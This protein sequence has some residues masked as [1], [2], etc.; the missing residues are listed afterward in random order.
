MAF[1]PFEDTIKAELI[2]LCLDQPVQNVFH[3]MVDA[4]PDLTTAEDLAEGLVA[5]WKNNLQAEVHSGVT[6]YSV[7]CT[8]MENEND[9]GILYTTGLPATGAAASP[10]MP[11][12]VT[13]AVQWKT[14]FR[15]R[16]YRGRTY[17]VGLT[18]SNCENNYLTQAFAASL[19]TIYSDLLSVTT[20]VGPAV[21][22]IASRWHNK[23]QR[24]T[25]VITPVVSCSIDR[26]LDSQRRRLP[27]R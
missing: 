12:N 18:E 13:V 6:L 5:W 17:H 4:T 23:V 7:E 14:A 22:G 2:F 1:V 20:N 15:G 9:P 8:I 3:Y 21:L 27:G 11:N 26:A 10:A 16:S 25:G 24:T 19:Q